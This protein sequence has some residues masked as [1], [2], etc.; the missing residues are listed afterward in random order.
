LK[1]D[2]SIQNVDLDHISASY[3]V[4][5]T[6]E[7]TLTDFQPGV[8]KLDLTSFHLKGYVSGFSQKEWPDTYDPS[9]AKVG[10][11]F[12]YVIPQEGDFERAWI[13]ER[14]KSDA[15]TDAGWVN[16]LGFAMNHEEIYVN[17][18]LHPSDFIL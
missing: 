13:V 9:T 6:L 7:I 16:I 14:V 2:K 17:Y 4:A 15:N 8:D 18:T 5:P 11:R 10:D 1:I 12:I 3:V